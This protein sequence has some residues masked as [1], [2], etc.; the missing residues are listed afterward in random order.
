MSGTTSATKSFVVSAIP[1]SMMKTRSIFFIFFSLL[2]CQC[3]CGQE[4]SGNDELKAK[5]TEPLSIDSVPTGC[6][7]SF[8]I[9]MSDASNSLFVQSYDTLKA[10]VQWCPKNMNAPG[11]FGIMSSDVQRGGDGPFR[12]CIGD[13]QQWLISAL[14]W[15]P[16]DPTYFCADVQA[17]EGTFYTTDTSYTDNNKVINEGLSVIYWILH[18][19]LCTNGDD[20]GLYAGS[21]QSQ[22]ENY[23]NWP[24]LNRDSVPFDTTIYTMH[25][26][27]LDS[28]LK[29]A[30]L[31]GV[32]N[33]T[34]SIITNASGYPNPAGAGTVI[35][36]GIAR[37]AYVN[38]SLCDVLGHQVSAVG[39]G[40]VV[41][42]GNQSV[43]MSLVG[44]PSGTYFARIQTTFGE[45]QTVKLVKE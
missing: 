17:L 12:Q 5:V 10:F 9:G 45:T 1:Q 39:F 2:L 35:S 36:F 34:P 40:S 21:R 24:G 16:G 41:E 11:A 32:S 13:Y 22:Y 30:G 33:N 31:L 27:G 42:P 44:L 29:Y 7:L 8:N 25:Q 20:S 28:V 4:F 15:N 23:L 3:V 19:P 14:A 18:N 26:L 43:P 6:Q 37:E 38:I